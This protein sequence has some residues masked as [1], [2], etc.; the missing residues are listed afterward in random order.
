M[1]VSIY[2][3]RHRDLLTICVLALLCLG[4]LMVQSA[5]TTITGDVKWGWSQR[6][7]RHLV[8]VGVSAPPFLLVGHIDYPLLALRWVGHTASALPARGGASRLRPPPLWLMAVAIFVCAA[9]LVPG[10]GKNVN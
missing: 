2:R 9:V 5:S 4:A 7:T 6:G 3:V 10:I 1:E 8:F